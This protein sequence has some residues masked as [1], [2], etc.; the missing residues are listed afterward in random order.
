MAAGENCTKTNHE[1]IDALILAPFYGLRL[2]FCL[3]YATVYFQ[4]AYDISRSIVSVYPACNLLRLLFECVNFGFRSLRL[5]LSW[6]ML[7]IYSF[8]KM[9]GVV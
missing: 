9:R 6:W 1:M 2:W 8:L 3:K 7:Y 4:L 5:E